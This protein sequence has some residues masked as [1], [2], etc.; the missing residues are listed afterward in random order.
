MPVMSDDCTHNLV[1]ENHIKCPQCRRFTPV[2]AGQ[3]SVNED[4]QTDHDLMDRCLKKLSPKE[5]AS[6]IAL[7]EAEKSVRYII[8][9]LD[10]SVSTVVY[11]KRRFEET[12]DV[13]RQPGSEKKLTEANEEDIVSAA[14]SKPIT[15]E[16]EIA[17]EL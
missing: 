13:E 15:T 6:I 8:A 5:R 12:G 1:D 4:L 7:A 17:G 16:Q 11:W 14:Q 2:S 9:K 10:I 3:I